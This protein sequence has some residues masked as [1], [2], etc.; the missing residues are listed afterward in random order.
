M[1]ESLVEAWRVNHRVT[2]KLIDGLP[3]AAM[4]ATLSARGGRDI[5]RQLAHVH[6]VRTAFLKKADMP[7]GMRQFEKDESPERPQLKSALNE[8]ADAVERMILR[9][10]AAGGSVGGYKRDVVTLVSY[11]IAHE[12]HHRGS[13]LL[14]AKQTGHRLGDD[15]KWGL[16]AWDTI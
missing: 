16:W 14:T 3:A 6:R 15:L 12:A 11:L 1:V 5:A 4:K 8:S 9:A 10:S 2:L 7:T 13:I